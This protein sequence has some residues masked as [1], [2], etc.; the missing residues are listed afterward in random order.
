MLSRR[1][2]LQG[3]V[4]SIMQQQGHDAGCEGV[5]LQR[6]TFNKRRSS[7]R[8]AQGRPEVTRTGGLRNNV[9]VGDSV[10]WMRNLLPG[11]QGA[12][13]PSENPA[14][15]SVSKRGPAGCPGL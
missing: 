3:D 10:Q 7:V 6:S 14:E 9:G 1:L 12:T 11:I 13:S 15:L 4:R 2:T 5:A 8:Q